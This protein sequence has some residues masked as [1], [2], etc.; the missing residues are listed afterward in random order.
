MAGDLHALVQNT[1]NKQNSGKIRLGY[2]VDS[3]SGVLAYLGNAIDN[4][5][6]SYV[7]GSAM[8]DD[9][10]GLGSIVFDDEGFSTDA[11]AALWRLPM[12][13]MGS[14]PVRYS[15]S[16]KYT[17]SSIEG[18]DETV[19][20]NSGNLKQL[21]FVLSEDKLVT[22]NDTMKFE[23]GAYI[24]VRQKLV[25]YLNRMYTHGNTEGGKTA[26]DERI[27]MTLIEKRCLVLQIVSEGSNNELLICGQ[28]P[29]GENK[30]LINP[31][32][33]ATSTGK[34]L[35]INLNATM[36][37][38]SNVSLIP[39]SAE[40][41]C[42]IDGK[43]YNV[44]TGYID[45]LNHQQFK[46][47]EQLGVDGQDT[48]YSPVVLK[49]IEEKPIQI[50]IYIPEYKKNEA[51]TVLPK[52]VSENIFSS[53]VVRRTGSAN[54]P[55]AANV[56]IQK[57]FEAIDKACNEEKLF[58]F[59][60]SD[61]KESNESGTFGALFGKTKTEQ[62]AWISGNGQN[63]AMAGFFYIPLG[64]PMCVINMN[65]GITDGD[66]RTVGDQL[67]KGLPTQAG[68]AEMKPWVVCVDA[69]SDKTISNN[70]R[71]D[72]ALNSLDSS[73]LNGTKE[74]AWYN[75]RL[76]IA[77]TGRIKIY[78]QSN[79]RIAEKFNELF[80]SMWQTYAHAAEIYNDGRPIEEKV[81]A[82]EIILRCAPCLCA[83]NGAGC[84]HRS[85]WSKKLKNTRRSAGHDTGQAIDFDPSNNPAGDKSVNNGCHIVKGM[86][87]AYRPLLHH[88]YRLGGGWGGSYTFMGDSFDAMHI[89]F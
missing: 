83:I 81:S 70:T 42:P 31:T 74:Q 38:N 41:N 76:Q 4:V 51:L 61:I 6:I 84:I 62:T 50:R 37:Q 9:Y 71:M 58:L 72:A 53:Y 5:G 19:I 33:L 29:N 49:Q 40:I 34:S 28:T 85:R 48:N 36:A 55:A 39:A 57:M 24:N 82:G 10:S 78:C 15:S 68:E 77:D 64:W 16:E 88:L 3:Y 59:K 43:S 86:E 63:T 79:G 30:V 60:Q 27:A 2:T 66:P 17:I 46:N 21:P 52:N 14:C 54:I 11:Q 69:N 47:W 89:Q 25:H 87:C 45:G 80:S 75:Q 22:T 12:G 23:S 65:Y 18:N 7:G 13:L 1:T 56:Q 73:I 20:Q 35:G 44:K 8:G 67:R 26:F 32:I